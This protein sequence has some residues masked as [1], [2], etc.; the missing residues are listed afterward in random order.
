VIVRRLPAW[1]RTWVP[2]GVQYAGGIAVTLLLAWL[3]VREVDFGEVWL[4]I[5]RARWYYLAPIAAAF[6]LR[7]WLRAVRW[8]ALV[9]HIR[10][11]RARDALPRVVLSQAANIVLPFQLGYALMVQVAAE[12]FGIGRAQ[13]LGS[14][15][16]ERLMDGA[17][18]ALF[19]A[20]SLMTLSPGA[21]FTGLT[22]F[23]LLGTGTGLVLAWWFTR[24]PLDPFADADSPVRRLLGRLHGG[25]LRPF[26]HGLSA[27]RDPRQTRDVFCLTAAIWLT[28]A[29]F[30]WLLGEALGIHVGPMAYVFVVGAANVGAGMP[31]VQSGVGLVFVAQQALVR[32]GIS[33]DTATAYALSVEALLAAPLVLVGPV[34]ACA[35]R[36]RPRDLNPFRRT[37]AALPEMAA[38]TGRRE[39]RAGD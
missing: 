29:V 3:L 16:L 26:Q 28:E 17:V 24:E 2:G 20:L 13:L 34:A 38:G 5:R 22:V 12:K 1:A 31:L 30:Y 10:P 32:V 14:E 25:F 15:A 39:A 23:M 19:L 4:T 18:F 21:G 33:A 37:A 27:V 6:A 35:L 36:L 8:R 9:R 11:V 7:Y